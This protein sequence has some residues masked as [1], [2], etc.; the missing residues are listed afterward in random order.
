[1]SPTK[2][3]IGQIV[4]VFAI[5]LLGVWAGLQ[6]SSTSRAAIP[7]SRTLGPSAHQ[8]GPSPSHTRIGVQLKTIPGATKDAAI[9]YMPAA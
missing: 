5:I 8:I 6:V 7:A 9:R 3:L 4:A 2:L 1:M